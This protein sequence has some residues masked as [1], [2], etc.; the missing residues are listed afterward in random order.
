[1]LLWA[2]LVFSAGAGRVE[3]LTYSRF[4]ADVDSHRIRTVTIEADGT[5]RGTLVDGRDYA[6]TIPGQAGPPL[7][8]RLSK[9]QVEIT[10]RSTASSA[11]SQLLSWLLLIA[12]SS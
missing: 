11:V 4:V 3:T 1:M 7:L 9:A 5:A 2:V 12:P 10:A 6:T 8:E